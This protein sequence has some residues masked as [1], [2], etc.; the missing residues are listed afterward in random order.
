MLEPAVVCGKGWPKGAKGK[1]SKNHG[2]TGITFTF[3]PSLVCII[4]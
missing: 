3:K 1:N 2:I 4:L